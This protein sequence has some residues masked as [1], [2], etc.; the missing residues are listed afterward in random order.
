MVQVTGLPGEVAPCHHGSHRNLL[1]S[2]G[3][4]PP[5]GRGVDAII[6]PTARRPAYLGEAAALAIALD[7]PLVTLH[8]GKWTTAAKAAQRLPAGLDLIAIDVPEPARLQLPRWETS[9]LLAG[10]VFARR[11]DVSAKRNLALML[12]HLLGWS[13]VLFLD[14]DITELNPADV[15]KA[16]SLLDTHN[17]V[18]LQNYGYPDNSVVCHAYRLA[19]GAQQTFI[20]AGAL[21]VELGRNHSFFP[22]IYNDDWFF[23]L[24][25][26]KWL[27]STAVT[28]RMRQHR[29]DPFRNDERAR[30]EELGDVLAEGL[31][32]LLDQNR[33]IIDADAQHWARF[34]VKRKQFINNVLAQVRVDDLE[35]DEKARRVA[36]LKGSLGRLT[37]IKPDLCE[38]YLQAWV[39]DRQQWQQHIELLPTEQERTTALAM[40]SPPGFPLTWKLG[41]QAA[42]KA[43]GLR[44]PAGS[45]DPAAPGKALTSANLSLC[46]RSR[47]LGKPGKGRHR[48]GRGRTCELTR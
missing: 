29:Y 7:C 14:D 25:G 37:L 43:A 24:D 17:A 20:G 21:A 27:Q 28:G 9:R 26:D 36:A 30:T 32:W 38:K 19:G 47:F 33:S 22:D 13:R 23:L 39:A 40:L 11:T 15:R 12:S 44:T 18:G 42:G 6:V 8:S 31:Y 45:S 2:A 10:T 3:S 41:G 1:W 46:D 34:L 5:P 35:P 4:S 16:S 48:A